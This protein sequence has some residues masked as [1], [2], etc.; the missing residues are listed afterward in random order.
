MKL[1]TLALP[2][3]SKGANDVGATV[4]QAQGSPEAQREGWGRHSTFYNAT[5]ASFYT[6]ETDSA[7]A[8]L[9]RHLLSTGEMKF[10]PSQ[11]TEEETREALARL[12][13]ESLERRGTDTNCKGSSMCSSCWGSARGIRNQMCS[14]GVCRTGMAGTHVRTDCNAFGQGLALFTNFNYWDEGSLIGDVDD[15]LNHNC[16]KCGSTNAGD[17]RGRV[18]INYVSQC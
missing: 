15:I 18:T 8:A 4:R 14:N 10:P 3:P 16:K 17:G 13:P 5:T 7:E 2:S 6:V 12:F 9:G 11:L 1:T